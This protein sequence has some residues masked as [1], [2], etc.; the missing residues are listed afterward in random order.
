MLGWVSLDREEIRE[1][2]RILI[3]GILG[4]GSAILLMS[5]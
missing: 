1:L 4:V 2:I 3:P 5:F